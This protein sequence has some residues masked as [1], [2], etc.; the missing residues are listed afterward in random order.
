MEEDI[1]KSYLWWESSAQNIKRTPITQQEKNLNNPIKNGQRIW[2]DI[3]FKDD[4][5]WPTSI[6]KYSQHH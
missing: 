3:F 2:I 6:W 1:C 4:I 5:Q